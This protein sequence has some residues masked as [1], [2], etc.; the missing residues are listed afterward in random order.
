MVYG[1]ITHPTGNTFLLEW[2]AFSIMFTE[3]ILGLTV[4]VFIRILPHSANPWW[5]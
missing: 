3:K 1:F 4:I 5:C 2:V